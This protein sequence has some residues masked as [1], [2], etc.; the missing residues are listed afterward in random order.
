MSLGTSLLDG[1]QI[2]SEQQLFCFNIG[3][4]VTPLPSSP[5]PSVNQH[6]TLRE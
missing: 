3:N 2:E 6:L 5:V 1:K 4:K